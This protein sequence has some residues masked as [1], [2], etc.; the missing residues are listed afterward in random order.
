MARTHPWR[1]LTRLWRALTRRQRYPEISYADLYTLA[2]KVAI[3]AAG[4]PEIVWRA[5]RVDELSPDAVTP[6]GRLP[7]ADKH[8]GHAANAQ[9]LCTAGWEKRSLRA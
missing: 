3:E 1:C 2:G 9:H 6:D 7:D 4:G 8:H 5:G